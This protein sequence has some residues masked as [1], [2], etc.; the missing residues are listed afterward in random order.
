[1]PR[2]FSTSSATRSGSAAGK[3]ILLITGII[4]RLFSMAI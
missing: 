1:M 2:V 3:S 4:L